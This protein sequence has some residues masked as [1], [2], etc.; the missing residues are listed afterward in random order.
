MH[1]YDQLYG[2]SQLIIMHHS[3]AHNIRALFLQKSIEGFAFE[4]I[5]KT[6]S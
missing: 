5:W 4:S 1:I 2:H 6:D 3:N